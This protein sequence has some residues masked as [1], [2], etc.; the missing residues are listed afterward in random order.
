MFT[1]L[2]L[3]TEPPNLPRQPFRFVLYFLKFYWVALLVMLLME[4]GQ[5]TC[6]ILIPYAVKEI[7]DLGSQLHGTFAEALAQ[8]KPAIVLFIALSIGILVFSRIS[9]GLLVMTGPSLRRR[10]RYSIYH[11]L[12]Y[13]SQ[14]FFISHFA[15][16]LANRVSEVS[17]GVNHV[18]WTILFDFVP[19]TVTFSV[20]LFLLYKA[21]AELAWLLGAWVLFYIV[22]SF[23]LAIRCKGY[24][25]KW[26]ATRSTV[27]GKIVDSVTN[28]LNT[29]L[30]ARL[31]YERKYLADYLNL[32]V[33]TARKTLWY[34]EGM[35]WF[36]FIATMALQVAMIIM[37]MR[38]WITGKMSVGSF[39]MVT[40]LALLIINEARGL[41]RRFLDFFEYVG[42]V[43][44]GVSIIVRPHEV[45]DLSAAKPIVVKE[46]KVEYDHVT[47]KYDDKAKPVFSNL[48][49]TIEPGQRIGLVGFS[50]SGKTSFVNL[51][52]RMYDLQSGMIRIDGQDISQCTQDSLREQISMIP[53]EP[54][55]FHRSLMDNI[56]Y[57]SIGAT[58]DDV[59]A[60]AKAAR[61]HEFIMELPEK[62]ESLVGERGVKLS[63]GQRQRIAIARAILKNAPI[64]M[65]DEATSSL[66]SVTEKAIQSSLETLMKNRT[67]IVVAHRLSTISY[68][69]RILVFHQGEV[70]EDGNHDEL[71]RRNGHYARLWRMQVGGFLPESE[72]PSVVTE[73]EA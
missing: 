13:H 64:L 67:V 50:G 6:Q 46:G 3:G 71:L 34:M 39:A 42:N 66:D 16:S 55:L 17:M 23:V 52:L 27:T 26:A 49:V 31:N 10:V 12:Q 5:A 63:G 18:L 41:S 68:L 32:E 61:A 51:I 21:N 65:L 47:F 48:S 20:S 35:R 70:I 43:A 19:V 73:R 59:I 40:S 37:A 56:R 72:T 62:Y 22:T 11:Y 33:K 7:I 14:K 2:E 30:F 44:D 58:D 38:F 8:L 54:M 28:V 69:D 29:K 24:A 25:K 9:G 36:Q 45:V 15:G 1:S 57:G 53:Q 60:A 4:I